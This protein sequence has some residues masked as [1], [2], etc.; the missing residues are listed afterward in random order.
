LG[1]WPAA[2]VPPSSDDPQ[3]KSANISAERATN[4]PF[5]RVGRGEI[6]PI[7]FVL[8]CSWDAQ[9]LPRLPFPNLH[10]SRNDH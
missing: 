7:L 8:Y 9:L 2:H 5:N 6:L 10:Y 4:V 3:R 1:F